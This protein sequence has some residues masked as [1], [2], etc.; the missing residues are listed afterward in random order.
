VTVNDQDIL[1]ISARMNNA[2]TGD[3]VNV[4]HVKAE[5]LD[6]ITDEEA[7]DECAAYMEEIYSILDN[8]MSN[9]WVFQDINVFNVTQ[10]KPVGVSTWPTLTDGD[11]SAAALPPQLTSFVRG[12]S[13]L[14]RNWARKFWGGF[15]EDMNTGD[16]FMESSL[17]TVLTNAAAAW[18]AGHVWDTT[19][20]L[21]PK[22]W[23]GKTG[24][25]VDI[26]E[27]VVTNVWST[28]R[29]RRARRGS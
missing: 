14:S 7:V 1:R 10:D 11:S 24:T 15:T 23:H 6:T 12:L 2:N 20:Y 29:T 13:G 3:M 4:Y 5:I 16:G 22:V 17:V 19:Q 25:W 9:D 28:Y 21:I 27:A 8:V 26:V 18:I